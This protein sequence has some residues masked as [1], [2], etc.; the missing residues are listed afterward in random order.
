LFYDQ[1][2]KAGRIFGNKTNKNLSE[3]TM[4]ETP[5]VIICGFGRMGQ[6]IAQMLSTEK[7]PY[8]AIDA[9]V[10]E[11]VMA[12]ESGYN[13]IYGESRK[14]AILL[15]AGLKPRK[16]R[17]VVISL[18][19]E[20][21]ARDIV[22]TLQ[23]IAPRIKIFAR[24]HNL[25]SS[26]ELLAMGVKSATPEI[27]ESSFMVGSNLMTG[28]GLSKAKINALVEFLRSDGYANIKKPIDVK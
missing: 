9:N 7:I 10:D 12:R 6:I 2:L 24:V 3:S 25:K 11:V 18:N 16:T 14:K 15:A 4:D 20:V 17:A 1:L 22:E 23:A 5:E 28:L 26:R 8:V 21:V 19:D 27:I 13:V